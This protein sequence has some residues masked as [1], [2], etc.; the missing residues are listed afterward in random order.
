MVHQNLPLLSTCTWYLLTGHLLPLPPPP[1]T[2][3]SRS[4]CSA[5]MFYE[6]NFLKF[7]ITEI[8]RYLSGRQK[9]SVFSNNENASSNYQERPTCLF[10][11]ISFS[12][13]QKVR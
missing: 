1:P 9:G 11:V 7:S 5:L 2:L 4:H 6:L 8:M 12:E 10:C 13:I 3:A